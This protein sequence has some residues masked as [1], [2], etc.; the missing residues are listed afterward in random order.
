MN[1]KPVSKSDL[2]TRY[3][4]VLRISLIINLPVIILLF[5]LI[6]KLNKQRNGAD[7]KTDDFTVVKIPI[8]CPPE[9]MAQRPARPSIPLEAVDDDLV[10]DVTI[11]TNTDLKI[12]EPWPDPPPNEGFS[13][14][15]FFI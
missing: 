11:E 15:A 8:V 7:L 13:V 5:V 6:P 14:I 10:E 9:E 2:K 4:I 12:N 3:P 1:T